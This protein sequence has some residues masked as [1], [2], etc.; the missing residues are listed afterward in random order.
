MKL[1]LIGPFPPPING[2]SLA[3]KMLKKG[4]KDNH[5][6]RIVNTGSKKKL[7]NVEEMGLFKFE[8]LFATIGPLFNGII[9]ILF[10]KKIDLVYITPGQANWGYLKYVPFIWFAHFRG[11][12]CVIHIHGGYFRHAYDQTSGWKRRLIDGSLKRLSGVIVLG[13][14]LRYMFEGLVPEEMIFTCP[15]GVEDEIFATEE[16]INKKIRRWQ[17]DD[18]IR[19]L[20]LSNL[21]RSKGI[22]DLLEAIKL[23]KQDGVK[24]HLDVAGAI[25]PGIRKEVERYF[26][27]LDKE[28]TYHGVVQ[29]E[30]KKEL[31]LRNYIFCLPTYYP[32]EGQPIS[33]LEAMANGCAIVTTDHGGIKDVVTKENG[34]YVGKSNPC[35]LKNALQSKNLEATMIANY[36]RANQKYH[37]RGFASRIDSI[38]HKI[39]CPE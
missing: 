30:K 3:N 18:T 5:I 25:E 37:C 33:I 9:L 7:G 27:E 22:L 24:V 13:E 2:M 38:L 15:N 32:N 1:L 16:E 11:I 21:L 29:G 6:I 34:I 20:Y 14:S 4:L 26:L 17:E 12:P 23:L 28:V 10:S 31:L 39:L 8:K 19:V 36:Q 35:D